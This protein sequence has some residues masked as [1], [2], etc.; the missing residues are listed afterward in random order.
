MPF[1]KEHFAT[2]A[3]QSILIQSSRFYKLNMLFFIF[4]MIHNLF[5]RKLTDE[6]IPYPTV[7]KCDVWKHSGI[8]PFI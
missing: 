3:Q 8:S 5:P 1:R 6:W 7:S 2:E 4:L